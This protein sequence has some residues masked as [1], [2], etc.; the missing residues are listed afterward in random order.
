MNYPP[1]KQKET[2]IVGEDVD[3]L[4]TTMQAL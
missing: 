1:S 4:T 3:K 2:E